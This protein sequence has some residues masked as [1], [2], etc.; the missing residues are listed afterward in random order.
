[1]VKTA[2]FKDIIQ[3]AMPE[4]KLEL[5]MQI[6]NKESVTWEGQYRAPLKNAQILPQ[7]KNGKL[8]I[9][10]AV[11]GPPASAIKAG[12]AGVPMMLTTLGGPASSFKVSVDVYREAAQR[13]G[14]DP[15]TLPIGTTSLFYTSENSQDA[16]REYY[17]HINYGM[18][19]ING[20]G[21]PNNNLP[22]PPITE[23]L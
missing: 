14:F 21:Y 12:Y 1:M 16:L 9:W 20:A 10:R 13:S 15:N 5:L 7:P 22:N 17:P 2:L 4:E 11:G 18:Q 19:A 8:P 3:R 6:N 23:M